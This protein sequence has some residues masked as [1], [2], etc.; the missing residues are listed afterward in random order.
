MAWRCTTPGGKGGGRGAVVEGGIPGL[1]AR[2]VQRG[3]LPEMPISAPSV[4]LWE[5]L[6]GLSLADR[7][8]AWPR[9]PE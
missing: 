5:G 4:D 2:P 3:Q 8:S 7:Y 9:L 6:M 1:G